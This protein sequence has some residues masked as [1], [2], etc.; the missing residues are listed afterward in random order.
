MAKEM[1]T[2]SRLNNK[3]NEDGV[4]EAARGQYLVRQE[5]KDE[6]EYPWGSGGS[7]SSR[8]EIGGWGVLP[9]GLGSTW[10]RGQHLGMPLYL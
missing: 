2:T 3:I 4:K 6:R 5:L 8:L 1:D 7:W 9:L 10:G